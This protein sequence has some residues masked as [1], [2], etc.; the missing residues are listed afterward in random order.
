M[1]NF[2]KTYLF[3]K[4]PFHLPPNVREMIVKF[5]PWITL[6]IMVLALPIIL[7]AFGLSTF[8]APFAM[9]SG[10]YHVGF[11]GFVIAAV[12]I[13][14]LVLEASALPGLFARQKRGWQLVYYA[15]LLSAVAQIL[16]GQIFGAIIGLIISMYFLF[17]IKEY[18]K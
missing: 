18:Y 13:A 8:L 11:F 15:S 14:S 1:E 2:F 4:A 9:M 16:S 17:Q 3:D 12:N 10:A 5:G 7:V 6:V